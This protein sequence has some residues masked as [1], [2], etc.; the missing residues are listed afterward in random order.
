MTVGRVGWV[1]MFEATLYFTQRID[2]V[3]HTLLEDHEGP[4]DIEVEEVHDELVT[5]VLRAGEHADDFYATLA[6]TDHVRHVERLDEENLLV[7]KPSCGAYS[8]IYRNH[9]TL[10]RHNAVR[11]RNRTYTVLCFRREDLRNIIEDLREIGTVSL[12]RLEKVGDRDAGLTERQRTV[13]T[14]A[15]RAGYYEWP[16]GIKSE[17]LAAELDISRATLHEHL[18][19]AERKLIADGLNV[20]ERAREGFPSPPAQH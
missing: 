5:F 18:R 2:C 1:G 6:A 9:G 19:K 8:A 12:G 4:V 17:E 16:R 15:L 11:G 7:T 3:L 14:H 10:R 20:D 13:V